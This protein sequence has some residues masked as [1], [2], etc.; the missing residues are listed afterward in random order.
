[1]PQCPRCGCSPKHPSPMLQCLQCGWQKRPA[2]APTS[3]SSTTS[4]PSAAAPVRPTGPRPWSSKP[5]CSGAQLDLDGQPVPLQPAPSAPA[6]V[7]R[8]QQLGFPVTVPTSYHS[9]AWGGTVT[10][11]PLDLED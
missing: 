3:P 5:P 2:S 11:T 9:P 4:T 10:E 7:A 6:A 1:V 8:G